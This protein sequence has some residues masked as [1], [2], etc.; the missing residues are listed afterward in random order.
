MNPVG[1]LLV[2][3]DEQITGVLERHPDGGIVFQYSRDWLAYVNK[4]VSLSL[5]CREKKYPQAIS[6]AFFE[7]LLP[8]SSARTILAFNH[9][10]SEKDTFA[11]LENFGEDCAGAL[12]VIGENSKPDFT[13]GQYLNID[14]EII[15]ALDKILASQG[16]HKLFPEIK[17]A[18]LS[19]AG[20]Q[21]K[22]PVYMENDHFF[23]PHDFWLC[24]HTYYQAN[25]HQPLWPSQK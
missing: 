4:P 25:K 9:R 12:S 17:N 23:L 22:L 15:M 18:R 21:D 2:I 16:S 10:F 19:I 7:N 8:E 14:R 1:K 24:H 6:T 5:P 3:W 20:A 13:P 11:F